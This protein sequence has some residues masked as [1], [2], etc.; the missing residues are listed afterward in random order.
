MIDLQLEKKF[1]LRL[2]DRFSQIALELGAFSNG[3]L[4]AVIKKAQAVA[5][6]V[7]GLIHRDIGLFKQLVK[8]GLIFAKQRDANA[9]RT[10]MG[11]RLELKGFV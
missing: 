11:V 7:L 9:A 5:P 3:L 10:V 4:H 8:F 6:L 1:E 2:L